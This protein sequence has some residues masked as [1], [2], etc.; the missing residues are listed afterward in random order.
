MRVLLMLLMLAGTGTADVRDELTGRWVG[1]SICTE[2]RGACHDEIAS[3]RVAKHADADKIT[4]TLNKIVNGEELTMGVNDFVVDA[5]THT[6]V[7]E[8]D[9]PRRGRAR[10]KFTWKGEE[11][12][13]TFEMLS[14]NRIGRNIKLKREH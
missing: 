9:T 1:T 6:L 10:V 11:M 3:Y 13:G 7:T 4:M 12:T 2:P 8:F 5:K 14:E